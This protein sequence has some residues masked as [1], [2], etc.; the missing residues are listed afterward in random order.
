MRRCNQL[1]CGGA[2]RCRCHGLTQQDQ[3][4]VDADGHLW[5]ECGCLHN[6]LWPATCTCWWMVYCLKVW[7]LLILHC[8]LSLQH[9]T[10]ACHKGRFRLC[11]VSLVVICLSPPPPN[12]PHWR[13]SCAPWRYWVSQ[14]AI[15]PCF[16]RRPSGSINLL[17][18]A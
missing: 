3:R 6:K 9:L 17:Q 2:T 8:W 11:P 13:C 1:L 18:R 14:Q 15:V 4:V 12:L 10:Y 5:C 16:L 7:I